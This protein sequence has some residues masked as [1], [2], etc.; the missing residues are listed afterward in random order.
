MSK[1][2]LPELG[3]GITKATIAL[4]H[5]KVGDYVQK[6]EDIVELVT[7]KAVFN[8]TAEAS[9]VIKEILFNEGQEAPIGAAL[10]IIETQ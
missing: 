5:H 3:E 10:A 8:V 4:W 2:L 6:D 9:G 1:V 7:D